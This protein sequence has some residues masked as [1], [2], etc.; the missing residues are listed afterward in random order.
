MKPLPSDAMVLCASRFTIEAITEPPADVEVLH[1]ARSV[2]EVV[3]VVLTRV[4][5]EAPF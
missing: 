3:V 4:P 5:S 1:T 2:V